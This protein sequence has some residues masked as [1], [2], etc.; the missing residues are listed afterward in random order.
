MISRSSKTPK[1]IGV[2]V[3]QWGPRP[4]SQNA[5]SWRPTRRGMLDTEAGFRGGNGRGNGKE[6]MGKGKELEEGR[7]KREKAEKG[8]VYF[9][10]TVVF[11]LCN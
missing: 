8:G 4:H 2:D 5:G 6:G 11:K 7:R 9:A 10:P 1:P 3:G